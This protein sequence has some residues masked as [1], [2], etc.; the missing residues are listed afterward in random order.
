MPQNHSKVS[1]KEYFSFHPIPQ[2]N[3]PENLNHAVQDFFAVEQSLVSVLVSPYFSGYS[4]NLTLSLSAMPTRKNEA[5][6]I[7]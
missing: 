6:K 4:F 5:S 1:K 7:S 3:N 2:K